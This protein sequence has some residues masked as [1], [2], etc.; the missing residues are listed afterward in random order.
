MRQLIKRLD[1]LRAYASRAKCADVTET[2]F[3]SKLEVGDA[4]NNFSLYAG[5]Y[6]SISENSCECSPPPDVTEC[7]NDTRQEGRSP[8]YPPA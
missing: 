3:V 4:I 1:H 5:S 7:C 8:L 6:I 2:E